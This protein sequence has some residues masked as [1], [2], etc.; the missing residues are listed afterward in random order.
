[1]KH[2]TFKGQP[3]HKAALM[4]AEEFK[5]GKL[6]RREFLAR[7]TSLG[8]AAAT[9]Y[10][11]GGLNMPAQAQATPAQGGTIKCQMSLRA[12]KDTRTADWSEIANVTR[13]T[14]EFYSRKLIKGR[15]AEGMV[16]TATA[17]LKEN[18]NPTEA[19]IRNYLEGNICRCTGY[20]NIVKSIMAAAGQDV[21]RIAAE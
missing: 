14:L 9:A 16:M 11:L 6:S 21:S 13:G 7:T 4:Y 10:A 8:V 12:L 20:H 1:M 3:I 2:T 19:E 17:L 15:E 5:D 18:P